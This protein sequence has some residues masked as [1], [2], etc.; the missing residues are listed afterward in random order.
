[1]AADIID[2]NYNDS[3]D[4]NGNDNIKDNND[5]V[6]R[7]NKE[8]DIVFVNMWIHHCNNSMNTITAKAILPNPSVRSNDYN[9]HC[10]QTS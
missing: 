4:Y 3:Y 5:D 10:G 8:I 2:S 7:D 9:Y 6:R 1:M